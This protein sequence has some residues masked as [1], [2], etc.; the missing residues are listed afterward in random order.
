MCICNLS[1]SVGLDVCSHD[2][3]IPDYRSSA[4]EIS[5]GY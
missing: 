2:V 3:K 4:M 1:D 5:I